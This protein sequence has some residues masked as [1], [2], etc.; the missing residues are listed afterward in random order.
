MVKGKKEVPILV[1]K[2]LEEYSDEEHYL[3]QQDI[4]DKLES[5]YA[6]E[7]E[8][9]S[10]ASTLTLLQ[11]LGYDIVKKSGGGYAL[12]SRLFDKQEVRYLNDAI[13]SSR[14]IPGKQALQLSNKLNSC[15]SRYDQKR[16]NY[17]YKSTEINRTSNP[18]IFLNIELIEE[19]IENKK[20]IAF[21][22]LTFDDKGN[23]IKRFNGF[24]FRISPYFLV[25]NFG[26]YYVLGHYR[27]KYGPI[28]NYRIDY[29]V[30]LQ[31][32]DEPLRPMS[33]FPELKDFD[34]A[35]Y[36]NEH[37][38]IFS[39]DVI[40]VKIKVEDPG[41]L[42]YIYDYFGSGFRKIQESDGLYARLRASEDALFYYLVQYS[43]NFT[44]V[45]PQSMID[46]MRD[47]FKKQQEKY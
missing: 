29:M 35:K 12:F 23:A 8:R 36:I 19:A 11:E 24:R 5:L 31:I 21:S 39:S 17:L 9:K 15:L 45:E 25:N 46:R 27:D 30:D 1:Y 6:I 10:V 41:A 13:F 22:Y 26:R 16:Y 3:T 28:L 37:I 14:T 4:I 38:Y 47:Y 34:I 44:V 43:K 20:K 2:I 18:Q 33:D 7:V 42:Q 32:T 40:E